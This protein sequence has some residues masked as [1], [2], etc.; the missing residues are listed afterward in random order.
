MNKNL[1]NAGLTVV[2]LGVL[3]YAGGAVYAATAAD[4]T[5]HPPIQTSTTYKEALPPFTHLSNGGTV[6]AWRIDTPM[7]DRPDYVETRIDGKTGYLKVADISDGFTVPKSDSPVV[8]ATK[9]LAEAERRQ[10]E[11]MVQPNAEGEVWAPVYGSDGVT[12]IGHQLMNTA[13]D[14]AQQ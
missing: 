3:G 1:L 11:V 2:V 6:G 4:D 10:K 12:V 8:D 13:K 7:E 9:E 14:S 5:D